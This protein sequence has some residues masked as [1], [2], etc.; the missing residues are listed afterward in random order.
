MREFAYQSHLVVAMVGLLRAVFAQ[1]RMILSAVQ[2]PLA[3]LH[4]ALGHA[5]LYHNVV[6]LPFQDIVPDQV[7]FNAVSRHHRALLLRVLELVLVHPPALHRVELRSQD[8]APE[9]RIT[10]AA[11][12]VYLRALP[13]LVAVPV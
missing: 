10:N 13:Q 1:V 8:I 11:C 3:Q 6:E 2:L 4:L 12:R 9:H 7:N 5:R